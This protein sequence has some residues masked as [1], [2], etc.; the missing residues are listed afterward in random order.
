MSQ[1]VI[2]FVAVSILSLF[3]ILVLMAIYLLD[4]QLLVYDFLYRYI[5]ESG[6]LTADDVDFMREHNIYSF[7]VGEAFM[8]Q[9]DPGK[10][11]QDIFGVN[12]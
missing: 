1:V 6:I 5:T 2:S 11:L 12:K 4:F 7:L 9:D 3:Q 8:R 10:A